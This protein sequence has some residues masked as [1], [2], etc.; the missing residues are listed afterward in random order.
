MRGAGRPQYPSVAEEVEVGLDGVRD[1]VVDDCPRWAVSRPVAVGAH[2]E[3]AR[4][5]PL[6]RDEE[7]DLGRYLELLAGSYEDVS[8]GTI[9]SQRSNLGSAATRP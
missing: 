3:H 4:V 7:R 9:T 2:R 5:V 1:D 6:A 8:R